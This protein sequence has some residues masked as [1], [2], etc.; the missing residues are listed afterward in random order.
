VYAF[1]QAIADLPNENANRFATA[2]PRSDAA[3]VR[4]WEAFQEVAIEA[5][6]HPRAPMG[7]TGGCVE[8]E[9]ETMLAQVEVT[10]AAA[11]AEDHA[12]AAAANASRAMQQAS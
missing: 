9:L 12:T 7:S 2:T 5:S 1:A 4:D 6:R 3:A 11:F 8:I 10:I